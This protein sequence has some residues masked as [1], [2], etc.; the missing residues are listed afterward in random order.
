MRVVYDKIFTYFK[1]GLIMEN[2]NTF[3]YEEFKAI[4]KELY[5]KGKMSLEEYQ[6]C[7]TDDTPKNNFN[8]KLTPEQLQILKEKL[9]NEKEIRKI[10][11]FLTKY[12]DHLSDYTDLVGDNLVPGK[13]FYFN[14]Q[15]FGYLLDDDPKKVLSKQNIEFRKK[16][17]SPL[18]KTLGPKFL[19]SKQIFE[20]RSELM[21]ER[22]YRTGKALNADKTLPDQKIVLPNEPV[23]WTLNH[24]FK[25]DALGSVLACLR[26]VTILFG[27]IPQFYNTFDGILAYLIGS[28]IINRKV[29][30][31]KK[32]SIEKMKYAM[33]LGSD[34]M[35]APEGVWNKDLGKL[36]QELWPGIYH[37]ACETGT[38]LIPVI[39]YIY[40]PTQK[41]DKKYNPIHTVIDDPVN[42]ASIGLSEKA[43]LEYYRD[44][45]AT[46]YY[47]MMEKYGYAKKYEI[48]VEETKIK[49]DAELESLNDTELKRYYN[50]LITKNYNELIKSGQN[51]TTRQIVLRAL[52]DCLT[53][54]EVYM[55]DLMDTVDR[56]DLS[57][58]TTAHYQPKDIITPLQVYKNLAQAPITKENKDSVE[59]A[60]KLVKE[61]QSYDFQSRF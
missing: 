2:Q 59:Y 60:R 57:I 38:N 52:K 3:T 49:T 30:S 6:I 27:S 9:V 20:N 19:N 29:S 58:E 61:Y 10:E 12:K 54:G 25:E 46:W 50:N 17:I 31:S 26:P 35:Y 32:A 55:Q 37:I 14:M 21:K 24:H 16:Y 7:L 42:L 4:A 22:D 11:E 15:H 34:I 40:D 28:I 48:K 8:G 53:A 23:I 45:M 43:A 36:L 51:L 33:S 56:Y 1:G 44:I 47:L 41:I 39:H 5:Q 18:I 13:F